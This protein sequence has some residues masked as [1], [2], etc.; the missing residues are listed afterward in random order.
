MGGWNTE[1]YADMSSES[2]L[3]SVLTTLHL[4]DEGEA[5]ELLGIPED[6]SQIALLPVAYTKGTDFKHAARPGPETITSWDSWGQA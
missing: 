1:L 5:A 2:G 6:V 4:F 3:G